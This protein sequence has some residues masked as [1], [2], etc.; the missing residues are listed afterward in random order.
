M[1]D[2]TRNSRFA[3][4]F[5]GDEPACYVVQG[6]DATLKRIRDEIQGEEDGEPWEG[7]MKDLSEP[8]EWAHD[9]FGPWSFSTEFGDGNHLRIFRVSDK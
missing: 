6:F 9:D 2:Y 5:T 3:V 4:V 8:N 7:F 1:D